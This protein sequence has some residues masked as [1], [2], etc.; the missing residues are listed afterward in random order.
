M[1]CPCRE[2]G[3]RREEPT[4]QLHTC[5][6]GKVI[7]IRN[8]LQWGGGTLVV[9]HQVR[10]CGFGSRGSDTHSCFLPGLPSSR[11]RVCCRFGLRF[12]R[13]DRLPGGCH[14]RL[15]GHL[16]DRLRRGIWDWGW[17]GG[18]LDN[19]PPSDY[20]IPP[21]AQ[22]LSFRSG[23]VACGGAFSGTLG[24]LLCK[25]HLRFFPLNTAPVVRRVVCPTTTALRLFP[26]VRA[27]TGEVGPP[28]R[29]TPR[30]VSAV[31]LC[32]SKA[33]AAP[34]LQWAFWCHVRLHRH[35]QAAE[36]HE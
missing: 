25:S 32:V 35:S 2:G 11:L 5:L 31:T 23:R 6:E 18:G 9:D 28:T 3:D 34:A 4:S 20:V 7:E 14:F 15:V 24:R 8:F 10:G 12:L 17:S 33:L 1:G 30:R 13:S 26:R 19:T 21:L 36:F 29:D 27:P 22:V 16:R